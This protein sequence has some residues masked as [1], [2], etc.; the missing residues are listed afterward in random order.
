MEESISVTVCYI[1]L[2]A[3]KV[4][5]LGKTFTLCLDLEK[6]SDAKKTRLNS[7]YRR[8]IET[9]DQSSDD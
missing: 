7:C 4:E 5:T 3:H 8:V 9:N 2:V 1:V 6:L